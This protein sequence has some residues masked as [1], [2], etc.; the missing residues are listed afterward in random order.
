VIF[1]QFLL[2]ILNLP[3]RFRLTLKHISRN[4]RR[5]FRKDD[6]NFLRKNIKIAPSGNKN[7]RSWD[8]AGGEI[9]NLNPR[10]PDQ[11]NTIREEK[12]SLQLHG[13]KTF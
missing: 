13:Q 10:A 6:K 8:K 3:K 1:I 11:A 4:R 9:F 12:S 7:R 5:K 2:E